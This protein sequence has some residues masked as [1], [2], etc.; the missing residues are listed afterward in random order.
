MNADQ[1]STASKVWMA[2]LVAL[3]IA[4]CS[5]NSDDSGGTADGRTQESNTSTGRPAGGPDT[6]AAPSQGCSVPDSAFATTTDGTIQSGPTAR[7]YKLFAPAGT[8]G[9]EPLPLVLAVH[10]GGS[11]ADLFANISQLG[12]L[13]Q[14]EGFVAVFPNGLPMEGVPGV[15]WNRS[16]PAADVTY[17]NDLLDAVENKMCIDTAR[18]YVTGF[19]LGAEMTT[20]LSCIQPERFAAAAPVSGVSQ[21]EPCEPSE[22]MPVV[23]LQ[24]TADTFVP[25]GGGTGQS[26]FETPPITDVVDGWA[27]RNGCFGDKIETTPAEEARLLRYDCP[28]GAE[29]DFYVVEGAGHT[30]AG[31]PTHAAAEA[32]LGPTNMN[33]DASRT[34]WEFFQQHARS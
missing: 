32:V 7:Q 3:A 12:S 24:G 23:V 8:D 28:P 19:S 6:P 30:W 2:I 33:L 25:F 5:S 34:I 29:V 14:Q 26:G 16:A 22:E 20:R 27:E 13:A 15:T 21:L 10:G 1:R 9:T 31:S 11:G 17:L 18:E 4:G